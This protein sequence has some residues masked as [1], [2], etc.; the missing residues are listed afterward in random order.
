MSRYQGINILRDQNGKRYFKNVKYPFIPVSD[1]DIYIITVTGD[2]IDIITDDYYKNVDDYWI[3]SVANNL[4]GDSRFIP[5]GT[6]LRIPSDVEG[7]KKA[8]NALNGIV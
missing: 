2:T 1:D 4:R 3:I 7:I 5:V 8:F 6:Q